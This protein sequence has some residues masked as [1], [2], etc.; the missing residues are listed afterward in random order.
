M[1]KIM[2]VMNVKM[3]FIWVMELVYKILTF[4]IAWIMIKKQKEFV[5]LV[6]QS[7]YYL[8]KSTLANWLIIFP[9][10]YNSKEK[11]NAENVMSVTN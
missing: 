11:I 4:Q 3:G 5:W 6:N 9:I 1:K 8:L 10:V 2:S 7:S